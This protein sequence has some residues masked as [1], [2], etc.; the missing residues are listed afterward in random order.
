M[1]SRAAVLL[2]ILAMLIPATALVLEPGSKFTGQFNDPE[3]S[4]EHPVM[5]V[6]INGTL[7]DLPSYEPAG[8][9][10]NLDKTGPISGQ[11]VHHER[12]GVPDLACEHTTMNYTGKVVLVMRGSCNFVLKINNMQAAGAKAVVVYDNIYEGWIHMGFDGSTQPE[13]PSVL[14]QRQEADWLLQ[15]LSLKNITE[16]VNGMETTLLP[17]NENSLRFVVT[18]AVPIPSE[19]GI[20]RIEGVV[21]MRRTV[22]HH[23]GTDYMKF[24]VS[25]TFDVATG[26]LSVSP[27]EWVVQP[28]MQGLVWFGL[29]GTVLP[30]GH[31]MSGTT[32]PYNNR[33]HMRIS[34]P[35]ECPGRV[36]QVH[37]CLT[38]GQNA[39]CGEGC[40][41]V[42]DYRGYRLFNDN[43]CAFT[44]PLMWYC[45]INQNTDPTYDKPAYA[46]AG[47]RLLL[48][49][50]IVSQPT[51][52]PAG[53]VQNYPFY[54]E[55]PPGGIRTLTDPA[56]WSLMTPSIAHGSFS[57]WFCSNKSDCTA[58]TRDPLLGWRMR[59]G[60]ADSGSTQLP[61]S[62]SVLEY[63]V[64]VGA[65]AQVH[66]TYISDGEAS[67]D[68]LEFEICR[69]RFGQ[70][71][72]EDCSKSV[73]D[74][75]RARYSST[76][77]WRTTRTTLGDAGTYSLRWNYVK[78]MS[79]NRGRDEAR[80]LE[81]AVTGFTD[82]ASCHT[83]PENH[84]SP[85][86][87]FDGCQRCPAKTLAAAGSEKCHACSAVKPA[88]SH[89]A[90][91]GDHKKRCEFVCDPGYN[92]RQTTGICVPNPNS[93]LLPEKS[94]FNGK[95]DPP[96]WAM[97]DQC[98]S[99]RHR[100][101]YCESAT[102]TI[103]SIQL[104][105]P[106]DAQSQSRQAFYAEIDKLAMALERSP[107]T[108]KT[109]YEFH[110]HILEMLRGST[111]EDR[112]GEHV[113][114]SSIQPN[115]EYVY[116]PPV[117]Y[118]K[119]YTYLPLKFNYTLESGQYR[120]FSDSVSE[121]ALVHGYKGSEELESKLRETFGWELVSIDDKPAHQYFLDFS[122]SQVGFSPDQATRVD[123]AVRGDYPTLWACSFAV[124]SL[125]LCRKPASETIKLKLKDTVGNV[126]DM[127]FPWTVIYFGNDCK[128]LTGSGCMGNPPK[129][130]E[131]LNCDLYQ[132]AR[133]QERGHLSND[134]LGEADLAVE[135]HHKLF[136][137]KD[138]LVTSTLASTTHTSHEYNGM[139]LTVMDSYEHVA[140]YAHVDAG[141]TKTGIL[142]V[143][144]FHGEAAE[145]HAVLMEVAAL[146]PARL[147]IDMRTNGG[148][149]VCH[150]MQ[151]AY[152][153]SDKYDSSLDAKPWFDFRRTPMMEWYATNQSVWADAHPEFSVAPGN[154]LDQSGKPFSDDRWFTD[155]TGEFTNKVSMNCERYSSLLEFYNKEGL[156]HTRKMLHGYD[157]TR[158][159]VLV[160]SQCNGACALFARMAVQDGFGEVV[161]VGTGTVGTAPSGIS[162]DL[163]GLY[164]QWKAMNMFDASRVPPMPYAGQNLVFPF[165]RLHS[166]TN[167]R[168]EDSTTVMPAD[169]KPT[170]TLEPGTLRSDARQG[171]WYSGMAVYCAAIQ[172][173]DSS[174]EQ[175]APGCSNCNKD[176]DGGMS[177]GWAF[178]WIFFGILLV[179]CIG[180]LVYYF[181]R[182]GC[183]VASVCGL[184]VAVKELAMRTCGSRWERSYG[185]LSGDPA[186]G[187]PS[188]GCSQ[189][190]DWRSYVPGMKSSALEEQYGEMNSNPAHSNIAESD[191]WSDH[192]PAFTNDTSS[193]VE[194]DSS[195]E[196]QENPEE[197][198]ANL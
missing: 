94:S 58:Q 57:T 36:A 167:T 84:C 108:W 49:Y 146:N 63:K 141:G 154:F 9:H 174:T 51:V 147:V 61:G 136:D 32:P 16:S 62:K 77:E 129:V 137:H 12:N 192:A 28:G 142:R 91:A 126:R 64:D 29:E 116:A 13:I 66:F 11:L 166:F 125:G 56:T 198:T 176:C 23:V 124:R 121:L 83:C 157:Q 85:G 119:L 149:H 158:I 194:V 188:Q 74:D 39:L 67:F 185:S 160:D 48:A 19:T 80:L 99:V 196:A 132:V 20:D 127:I 34:D 123:L 90:M 110:Q 144:S 145:F 76:H 103:T 183:S 180:A 4:S 43:Q 82:D 52:C 139:T 178:F 155:G 87:K 35:G 172:K 89:F 53:S 78:D 71:H 70:E 86:G 92:D 152:L 3:T 95:F 25:G 38:T 27:H 193:R 195:H 2:V 105:K 112:S 120:V 97:L 40:L 115:A 107:C 46:C 102:K 22:E 42:T 24:K 122:N 93:C 75:T 14:I 50:P 162:M 138:L 17:D 179:P 117:F 65:G 15:I 169:V 101:D 54:E 69:L 186:D 41:E 175:S 130:A 181:S 159:Q 171:T 26:K 114:R 133:G 153:I 59:G 182:H 191:V 81:L 131:E 128:D 151:L 68:F 187:M 177:A 55:W 184:C 111:I 163:D 18:S 10:P 104:A 109:D 37:K 1:G 72:P 170:F 148:G 8:I 143:A 134:F 98:L 88:N 5:R 7:L 173:F 33:F 165:T 44:E 168:R 73:H 6:H 156:Q 106:L 197:K 79:T 47:E 100:Q 190:F 164:C 118:Q 135:L 161:A 31:A 60:F 113:T 140:A 45:N 21:D 30:E 189:G 96:S 150:A